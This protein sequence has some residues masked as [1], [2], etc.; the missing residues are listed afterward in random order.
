MESPDTKTTSTKSLQHDGATWWYIFT[1]LY[2]HFRQHLCMLFLI[3][4]LFRECLHMFIL[5]NIPKLGT[6]TQWI[7]SVCI[8][9]HDMHLVT[10]NQYKYMSMQSV[11]TYAVTQ[12]LEVINTQWNHDSFHSG[13]Y[14]D[15]CLS[16]SRPVI[17][18]NK[19]MCKRFDKSLWLLFLFPFFCCCPE[20]GYLKFG[21]CAKLTNNY[22]RPTQNKLTKN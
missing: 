4:Q 15:D 11:H 7:H 3:F 1:R 9:R 13:H 22:R 16:D 21:N 19:T 20:Q 5:S 2:E 17:S 18:R 12:W 10:F 14:E 8:N 6:D